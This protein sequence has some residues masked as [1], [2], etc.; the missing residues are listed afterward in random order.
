MMDRNNNAKVEIKESETSVSI[1]Y[2]DTDN[3]RL[4]QYFFGDYSLVLARKVYEEKDLVYLILGND[5]YLLRRFVEQLRREG[6]FSDK[7]SC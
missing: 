3:D 6:Y 2:K 5:K 1:A 4:I 7:S